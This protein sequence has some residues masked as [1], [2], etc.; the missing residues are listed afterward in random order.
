MNSTPVGQEPVFFFSLAMALVMAL[1]SKYSNNREKTSPIF[2]RELAQFSAPW[3][4]SLMR[5]AL[6][7]SP[8]VSPAQQKFFMISGMEN[9]FVQ[10][11]IFTITSARI[12]FRSS[13]W[14][15]QEIYGTFYNN[16]SYLTHPSILSI[17]CLMMYQSLNAI[18]SNIWEKQVR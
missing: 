15:P 17:S 13:L 3:Q 12:C 8:K 7:R 18:C 11:L 16:A 6:K 10:P 5:I 1:R 4:L 14:I 9:I 2:G